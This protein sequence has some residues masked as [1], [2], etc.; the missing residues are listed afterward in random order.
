MNDDLYPHPS[1]RPHLPVIMLFSLV[2]GVVL[3]LS[4][5]HLDDS[6]LARLVGAGAWLSF[7]I[8]LVAFGVQRV[9]WVLREHECWRAMQGTKVGRDRP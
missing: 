7:G 5:P 2:G 1:K 4:A 8:F 3:L 6:D 9:A